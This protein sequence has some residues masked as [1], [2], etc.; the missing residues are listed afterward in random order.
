MVVNYGPPERRTAPQR[1]PSN[2]PS[3]P[4]LPARTNRTGTTE[5]MARKCPAHTPWLAITLG[6]ILLCTIEAAPAEE[7]PAER[8]GL[9]F[10][11]LHCAQCHAIDKVSASPVGNAPPL[12]TLNLKYGVADLQRPLAEGIHPTMPRF[13]LTPGEIED[14]MAYLKTLR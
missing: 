8:R 10:V 5:R 3:G 4:V 12:R 7:S 14:V 11:R 13:W 1:P 9:R 2:M 6:A